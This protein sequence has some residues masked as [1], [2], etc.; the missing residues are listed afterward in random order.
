MTGRTYL[1][2]GVPITIVIAYKA[3]RRDLPPCP[4]WLHWEKPPKGT[5]RN[6]AVRYPDGSVTVRGFRGLRRPPAPG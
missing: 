4:P 2:A 6:V 3:R 1:L 5:P